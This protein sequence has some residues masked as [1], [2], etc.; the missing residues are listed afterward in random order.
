MMHDEEYPSSDQGLVPNPRYSEDQELKPFNE[1]K[2]IQWI[3]HGSGTYF[4]EY[5]VEI[6]NTIPAGYYRIGF[7]GKRETYFVKNISYKT[8]KILELPMPETKEIVNDI[9][10]F[11]KNRKKFDEYELTFK[12]GVLMYGPP[13]CGKSHI[14][15]L[16]VK[17]LIEVEKGVVFKIETPDDLEKYSGFMH[18]TFKVIEP[19]RRIVTIMEDVDAYFRGNKSV[20][21][22]LLNILDG[23]NHMD[24]IVYLA[25]TNYPEDLEDR[26]ANR[27]S[28]FDS[29]HQ[30]NLPNEEVR[31]YY[32]EHTLKA[33]DLEEI[34]I[35]KWVSESDKMSIAH[36]RELIVSTVIQGNSF[37]DSIKRLKGMNTEIISSKKFGQKNTVGFKL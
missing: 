32:L 31:K 8:D 7:D 12:R 20:E 34:D 36:L 2:F 5:H 6:A 4:P 27:P 1:P 30:I 21:S 23:M 16:L 14:I 26:I 19:N 25:T 3:T 22:L 15:Q 33:K 28:R 13:G 24:N 29:R 11:W 10:K 18:S 17:H 35:N 9:T 37:E